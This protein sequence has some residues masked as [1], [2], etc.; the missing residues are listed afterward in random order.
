MRQISIVS[1]LLFFIVSCN[2]DDLKAPIPAYLTINDISVIENDGSG[3]ISDDIRDAR[4]FIND[5]SLGTFELPA[6]IPIQNVGAVNLKIRGGIFNNGISNN[7]TDY[8]FYTTYEV[9]TVFEA[10]KEITINPSVQYFRTV[11]FDNPWSGEDFESGANFEYHPNSDTVFIRTTNP[12][13]V[14]E[15]SASGLVF[16]SEE[17]DFFEAWVPTFSDIPRNGTPVY[18]EFDYKSDKDLAVSIYAN[19]QSFNSRIV[20]LRSNSE[21]TKIY[22]E[23]GPVFST[24]STA[25]NYNLAMGFVKPKGEESTFLIDNVKLAHF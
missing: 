7:R 14:F 23:L 1:L 8:P 17:H 21:W 3:F 25:N 10:E 2:K 12:Q 4:V 9:D 16:L 22:I 6:S 20:F 15:G 19:N 5:Q 18:M 11:D 24:L 13:Q